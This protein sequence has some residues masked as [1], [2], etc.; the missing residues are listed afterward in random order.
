MAPKT[1]KWEYLQ[2]A[3]VRADVQSSLTAWGDAGWE[4]VTCD[5]ASQWRDGKV[6]VVMKREK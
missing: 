5:F 2:A 4:L 6:A 3:I 1:T